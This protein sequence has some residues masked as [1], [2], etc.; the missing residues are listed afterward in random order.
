MKRIWLRLVVVV[1][2][3]AILLLPLLAASVSDEA[4]TGP[5]PVRITDYQVDYVLTAEGRLA[6]KETLTTD[7]PVGRHGIFRFWDV[8]DP[9]DEHVRLDPERIEVTLDGDS[10]PV[11]LSSRQGGRLR[12]A[13][14]GDPDTTVS[15]GQHTYTISYVVDDALS[16]ASVGN[17]S[18]GSSSWADD[19]SSASVFYWNVVPQGWQMAI[20]KATIRLTLPAAA[21]AGQLQCAVGAAGSGLA[22]PATCDLTGDGTDTV[23]VTTG[24]LAPRTPVTVRVGLPVPTPDRST[25]PWSQRADGSL[26]RSGVALGVVLALTLLLAG[27]GYALDRRSRER[28]PGLPV[29]YEPP[30]GLGPVQTAYLTTEEV[31]ERALVATLMFQA[32]QGLTTLTHDDEGTWT[33]TGLAEAEAWSRADDVTRSVGE[34]LG[35]TRPGATFRAGTK[36]VKAG[37]I[38]Q[39][40]RDDLPGVVDRWADGIGAQRRVGAETAA[41]VVVVVAF[42]LLLVVGFLAVFGGLP[43]IYALPFAGFALGGA[44]LLTVGVGKRRTPLG[45]ELWSQ[46]GGFERLLSTSSAKDRFDFSGKKELYTSF[47]PFAVAFDCADRWARKYE[48]STG[49]QPPAPLWLAGGAGAGASSGGGFGGSGGDFSGFER[50]LSGAISAYSAT[51]ASSSSSSGGGGGGGGGFSGGGGGG[52]GGG[53][54]W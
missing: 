35:V 44:G 29:V 25:V 1:V 43:A 48:I 46:S 5:D 14:I 26:G 18:S 40:T 22:A 45:R 8:V 51:Q 7:F 6:A 11:E 54:S 19:T 37:K 13:K 49:S 33:V 20:D 53:G 10:V 28:T 47:I 24:A 50:S 42:V 17:G 15:P 52:G 4:A 9:N 27:V 3:A 34:S 38:L 21:E 30:P 32:E 39:Q 16:P 41:R 12:V 36:T 2:A 31:P 23:T